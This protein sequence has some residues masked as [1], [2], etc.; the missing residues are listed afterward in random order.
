M[1]SPS[2]ALALIFL[3]VLAAQVHAIPGDVDGNGVVNAD[4][5]RTISRFLTNQIASL[6]NPGAADATQDGQVNM[7]DAFAIAKH[8]AGQSRV[9]E[10][11]VRHAQSSAFH[12]GDPICVRI[13][14]HFFP[15]TVTGGT[16]RIR[17]ASAGYDSGDQPLTFEQ[18]GRSL[19]F[20]WP[21]S[22]R[23]PTSDYEV[24]VTAQTANGPTTHSTGIALAPE[25][26]DKYIL[27]SERDLFLPFWDIGLQFTRVFPY[28]SA[29]YGFKGALGYGWIH[30]FGATLTE[31]TDGSVLFY[32]TMGRSRSGRTKDD[33][34]YS[35]PG[36]GRYYRKVD[37]GTYQSTP[38]D[39]SELTRDP[40]GSFQLRLATGE[41][42][43]FRS[44][45]RA[46]YFRS[47]TGRK[48]AF[49]YDAQGR[50]VSLTADSGQQITFT[51]DGENR[52][53]RATDSTGR[54]VLYGYDVAGHL[55]SVADALGNTTAYSYDSQHRL[56]QISYPD[57]RHRSIA[58]NPTTRH[59][60][61][62]STDGGWFM[63]FS[64]QMTP[65][66]LEELNTDA[67]GRTTRTLCSARGLVL[68][69][70]NALGHTSL[71]H[72]DAN[73]RLAGVTD[74]ANNAWGIVPDTSGNPAQTT[75][76]EL[77]TI[78]TAF[79]P[80]NNA[81]TS[82]IDGN[83]SQSTFEYYDSGELA[84]ITYPGG[85]L[86]MTAYTDTVTGRNVD[87]QLRSGE[88]VRYE[89]DQ[90]GLLSKK[91]YPG[92]EETTFGYD[93]RGN[94]TSATNNE[95][96]S[97]NFEYDV[98]SR[99]T[100]VTY[101]GTRTILYEYD[102]MSRRTKLTDPDGRVLTY[103]Y[104]AAG[105][106]A[107]IRDAVAGPV[108]SY[109]Y[110]AAGQL[111]SRSLANGVTTEFT[112]DF[113][114][115]VTNLVHRQAGGTV[116]SSWAYEYD[117]LGNR[118]KKTG[119]AGIETYSYDK[120]SQI[121]A[122]TYPGGSAES[123]QYDSA[124][125]RT[126]V[127][128]S[129]NSPVLYVTNQLNQYT[130]VGTDSLTYDPK[131][132]LTSRTSGGQT[133]SYSYD[134]E[135]RLKQVQ[136]PGGTTITYGYDALGRL[137]SRSDG[138]GTV[139]YLWEG[140]HILLEED[141]GHSTQARYTWGGGLDEAL[142]MRR[143]GADYYFLQD[144]LM[145]VTEITSGTGDVVEQYSY[146]VNGEASGA[147]LTGNPFSFSGAFSDRATG[148]NCMRARWYDTKLGRFLQPDPINVNGG[149]NLYAYALNSSPNL[150]DPMGMCSAG[151]G[152]GGGYGGGH[153]GVYSWG[154]TFSW[155][156]FGFTA[157]ADSTGRGS[158]T[159]S[160]GPGIGGGVFV[161]TGGVPTGVT[162][163]AY[164]A[165]GVGATGSSAQGGGSSGGV[166]VGAGAGV[167]IGYSWSTTN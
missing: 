78:T 12:T 95:T 149:L 15:L 63:N 76:P 24:T 80:E 128:T 138:A 47:I 167:S 104:D 58:Y 125:N 144:A 142:S 129:G 34:Y 112:Y 99:L 26:P 160:I 54:E 140:S 13:T 50:L 64:F 141:L 74:P 77:R 62:L 90:R 122:A 132:N 93:A 6:P 22:L 28:T 148:L 38:G 102:S 166:M 61:Q 7:E 52:I 11:S 109:A 108:A 124:G 100:K 72:Y 8:V 56:V 25:V 10:T 131:G 82:L 96:G 152:Y 9:L 126:S 65:A 162:V 40:D 117:T 71:N 86:E 92:G 1:K 143:S 17:S 164:G 97:I 118:T 121:T 81:I 18:D 147:A 45:L 33:S 14:E 51:Y 79:S 66:G 20:N 163:S 16:V 156:I 101:P 139:R 134:V 73:A 91:I 105:R 88:I 67:L 89:H 116:I 133:T 120:T 115:R 19:Y 137:A 36:D 42:W 32:D 27:A 69:R 110:D 68:E 87:R 23:Q 55:V 31:F 151:G 130:A 59:L 123:Y 106:L 4:D 5:A 146:K 60:Q 157:T 44:D 48:V 41:I 158:G 114:G 75:D 153:G 150:S 154:G 35:T 94:L 103:T 39:Y 107:E 37:A 136:L 85:A 119:L 135:N 57:G 113:A 21:T 127:T 83:G 46:D 3:L 98:L 49:S 111:T 145:S 29:F 30:V 155:G 84:K 159:I 53:T 165:W 43:K 2:P 70:E 161:S